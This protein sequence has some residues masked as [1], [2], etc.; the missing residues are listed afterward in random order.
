MEHKTTVRKKVDSVTKV[1]EKVNFIDKKINKLRRK[2]NSKI[3]MT[4]VNYYDFYR[5]ELSRKH[6]LLYVISM[7]LFFVMLVYY[8]NI[9]NTGAEAIDFL[10]N[11]A[12]G[13]QLLGKMANFKNIFNE[14]ILIN[15][16]ILFAGITPYIYI[17]VL[18][19]LYPSTLVLNIINA[20]SNLGVNMNPTFMTIGSIIQ[21]FGISLSS[22]MGIYFCK[23]STKRFKYNQQMSFT[24][25]DVKKEIY[26]IRK[27]EEKLNE[28]LEK[29]EEK[30]KKIEELNVKIPYKYLIITFIIS[31][32]IVIFGGLIS[33]I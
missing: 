33:L 31:T 15:L 8:L 13:T 20:F 1:N 21:M 22:A 11:G 9:R 16:V 29:E 24:F 27:E 28:L 2:K 17:P 26:T 6:I 5:K 7:I 4:I 23:V 19:I 12:S 30:N 25:N 14:K 18:G 3:S 32:L 10:K